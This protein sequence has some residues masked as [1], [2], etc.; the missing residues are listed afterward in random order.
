MFMANS[1]SIV[2]NS[3]LLAFVVVTPN[4]VIGRV[5]F[6]E[7]PRAGA[8]LYVRSQAGVG[9][10][11]GWCIRTNCFG[12]VLT[13]LL[14]AVSS[15]LTAAL[16]LLKQELAIVFEDIQNHSPSTCSNVPATVTDVS[17]IVLIEASAEPPACYAGSVQS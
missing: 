12:V 17:I 3:S 6:L 10:V 8:A 13:R 15:G 9:S 4:V 1:L 11:W 14:N 2:E 7:L 5:L 16:M